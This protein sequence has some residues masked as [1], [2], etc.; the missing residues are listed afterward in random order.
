MPLQ[1]V[2]TSTFHQ[3]LDFNDFLNLDV[4]SEYEPLK[5]TQ[6]LILKPSPKLKKYLRFLNSF[7]FEY[8][9]INTN[10]VFS[11]RKDNSA[12]T[13]VRKHAN[14][15]YFFQTDLSS[16]FYSITAEDVKNVLENYMGNSPINDLREYQEIIINMVTVDGV[17]P[18]GFSTS[19][20]IS[21]SCLYEFDN[22]LE[23]YC[24][25]D[26]IIYTRYSD[27]IIL[28]SKDND[29]KTVEKV[30]SGMLNKFFG[31]RFQLNPNKT[32]HTHTGKKI[33]LLGMV[34]LPSGK[35]SVD[36]KLKKQIEIL[37]YFYINDKT[38]FTDYLVNKYQGD[39]GKISGQLNYINTIDKSYL[40]KLR[41][42]Y[43]NFIVDS[44]IHQTVS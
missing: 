14:S 2:F 20:K 7:I 1:D 39:L 12:Y 16:F 8:A 31:A 17:L 25:D 34:I 9:K 18:V 37:F 27:D 35:V 32:K 24:L 41:K 36:I 21:N 13:A 6:K 43:G 40:N 22:E 23:Q 4:K 11:Y 19:P 33:K 3:K 28:S 42:K 30:I 5:N 26:G 44:F 10:V 38:K 15:K 29:L